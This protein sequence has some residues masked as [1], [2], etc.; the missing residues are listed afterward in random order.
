MLVDEDGGVAVG[1]K[2]DRRNRL[3][4]A[5]GPGG[6]ASVYDARSGELLKRYPLTTATTFVNDVIVTEHAAY[7]TDS[8]QRQLYVLDL[9]RHGKLPKSARTLPLTG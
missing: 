2:V 7:F 9:G 1:M 3:F 4:V 6:T 5:G 8:L